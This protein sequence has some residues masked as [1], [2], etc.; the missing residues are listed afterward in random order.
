MDAEFDEGTL[1]GI[2]ETTGGQYFRAT[3]NSS[4]KRIYEQI[5]YYNTNFNN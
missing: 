3:D 5:Q 2:A 1:R 4:L